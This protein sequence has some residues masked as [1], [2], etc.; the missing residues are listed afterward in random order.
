MNKRG[1]RLVWIGD[2]RLD[3]RSINFVAHLRLFTATVVALYDEL[4]VCYMHQLVI[5]HADAS[6][7]FIADAIVTQVIT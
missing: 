7:Q 4:L 5:L 1:L 3:E 2:S 6:D